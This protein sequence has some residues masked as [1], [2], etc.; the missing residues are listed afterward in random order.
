MK[1]LLIIL[2]LISSCTTNKVIKHHGINAL[3][4]KHTKVNYKR[5]K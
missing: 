5:N 1:K 4:K 2:F 3:E